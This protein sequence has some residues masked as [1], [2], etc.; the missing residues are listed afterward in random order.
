[1][2]AFA[3]RTLSTQEV[4]RT[5]ELIDDRFTERNYKDALLNLERAGRIAVEP[6]A[7][8]RRT[9]NGQ[10]TLADHVVI[11]FPVRSE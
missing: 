7:S 11:T 4:M 3:G 10:P 9:R 8:G 1:M 5:Y 6:P 2:E